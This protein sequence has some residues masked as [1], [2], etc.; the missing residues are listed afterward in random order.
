MWILLRNPANRQMLGTSFSPNPASQL[1][2]NMMHKLNDAITL[3]EIHDQAQEKVGRG[4]THAAWQP[5]GG[6]PS[7]SRLMHAAARWHPSRR[8]GLLGFSG[9]FAFCGLGAW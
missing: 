3:H 2:K 7:S 5:R 4:A 6:S 1:A 8:V 9:A